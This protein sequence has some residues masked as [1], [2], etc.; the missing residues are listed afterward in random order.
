MTSHAP[1]RVLGVALAGGHARRMGRPKAGIVVEDRTL[2]SRAVAALQAVTAEVVVLSAGSIAR[3]VGEDLPADVP[4]VTDDLPG[5]GPLAGLATA[6]RLGGGGAALA[7][8][9]GPSA[10][11]PRGR[12]GPHDAVLVVPIDHPWIEPAVLQLLVDEL[13]SGDAQASMLV[14][15]R[16]PQP[17][18]A[19]YRP[20]TE[21]AV[22]ALLQAGERRL[23]V[24]A[25]RLHVA[26]LE[27]SRWLA[28]DPTGATG[29]DLDTPAA[30]ES[31]ADWRRRSLATLPRP[32]GPPERLATTPV[33]H[34]R[35]GCPVAVPD[36][37]MAE[38][39]LEIRVAGP[40]QEP[41]VVMTTLRTPGHEPEQA[42]G[43]LVAEGLATPAGILRVEPGRPD[44]VARPEDQ[45]TV[46]LADAFDPGL[47]AHRHAMATASCGVCG[48]ASIDE[49][50][51]RTPP[52]TGD[53]FR[54]DPLP[55]TTLATLPDELRAAQRRFQATGGAHATGLFDREGRLMTLRED[56]GRHNALDAAI[57][58]HVLGG[59]WPQRGLDDLV[60]VLSGR[61][62]FELVAKAAAARLGIVAAVG[63]ATNLAVASARRLGITLVG[64][65]REGDG[66]VYHDPGRL[67]FDEQRG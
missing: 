61:V 1:P 59:V 22:R 27:S 42:A 3:A 43:W 53:P 57:G 26:P 37:L 35:R 23:Q 58:A 14:T 30:L 44:R 63:A 21:P 2:V 11:D 49:L 7:G 67:A 31:A 34:V 52:V 64:F 29:V 65:L 18:L 50:A 13:L 6:L 25:D 20:T 5:A 32:L 15:A 47:V 8:N 4:V 41:L 66:T 9:D 40:G 33:V 38:A 28:L 19:A 60:C 12:H 55:W 56:V 45:V 10:A 46:H 48:R 39:P 17:L 24:L 62:G 36:R 16:G 51:A 54:S